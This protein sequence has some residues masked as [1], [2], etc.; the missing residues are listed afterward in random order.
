MDLMMEK[1]KKSKFQTVL[2]NNEMPYDENTVLK[3]TNITGYLNSLEEQI[4]QLITKIAAK[5]KDPNLKGSTLNFNELEVKTFKREKPSL[6]N[7]P[8]PLVVDQ[9]ER[10]YSLAVHGEDYTN[11]ETQEA[12]EEGNDAS[13]HVAIKILR[14]RFAVMI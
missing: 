1:F 12:E 7:A 6:H 11:D 14:D 9:F 5:S 4:N 3:E 8:G 2:S 13:D 10:D